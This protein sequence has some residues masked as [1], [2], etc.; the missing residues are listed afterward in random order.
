MLARGEGLSTK[1]SRLR[2]GCGCILALPPERGFED[3]FTFNLQQKKTIAQ[4]LTTLKRRKRR[5]PQ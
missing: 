1:K 5:A 3:R 2:Q 4:C